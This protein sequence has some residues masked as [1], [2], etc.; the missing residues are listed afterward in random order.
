[1]RVFRRMRTSLLALL[2]VGLVL[3]LAAC[4]S[5]DD[6]STSG[7]GA[8]T[9]AATQASAPAQ[10]QA[11]ESGDSDTATPAEVETLKVALYPSTDYAAVYAGIKD[12]I[13]EKHGIK[14]DIT[15]VLTGPGLVAAITSGKSDLGTNSPT[16]MATGISNDLP[17][18]LISAADSIPS[19]GYVELLV[20]KDSGVSSWK[21][22][23]GKTIAAGNLQGAF[24]LGVRDAITA[25]GGDGKDVKI[26]A[27][28]PTQMG[29]AL[30]AGRVDAIVLQDPFL[31]TAKANPDFVSLGNPFK[32][33]GSTL[34]IGAFWAADKVIPEKAEVFKRFQ[35]AVKESSELVEQNPQLAK[36]IIPTYTELK[37]ADVAKLALPIYSTE[38]SKES[39]DKMLQS[40]DEYGW[41]KKPITYDD[42]VWSG[43]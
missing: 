24:D 40:M 12:G 1:M 21:D 14:L 31:A 29:A 30:S 11:A 39:L 6:S 33:S 37:P 5:S 38:A 25:D 27:M 13:F 19:E 9:A 35:E 3:G 4:G 41:L 32:N 8:D 26:L 36:D 22:L 34:P 17:V 15:Q 20:K 18:K 43:Q 42:I 2:A 10:T 7:E 16:G 23:V 28:D